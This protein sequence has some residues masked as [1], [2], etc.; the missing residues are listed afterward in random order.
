MSPRIR[1][2]VVVDERL[3]EPHDRVGQRVGLDRRPVA[4]GLHLGIDDLLD[5]RD[6]TRLHDAA[7]GGEDPQRALLLL[8]EQEANPGRRGDLAVEP[9]ERLQQRGAP[10]PGVASRSAATRSSP[11]VAST[12]PS[13]LSRV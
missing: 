4:P 12:S 8:R 7:A 6:H 3:A 13:R 10:P 11:S 1:D 2:R 5:R 9:V